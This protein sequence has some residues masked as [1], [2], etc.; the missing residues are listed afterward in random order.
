[1]RTRRGFLAAI[2][3][4]AASSSIAQENDAAPKK[5]G[6][7]QQGLKSKANKV[8]MKTLGGRQ[9]WGD[10]HYFHGWRIQRNVITKHCRL[11]DKDDVRRASG[12][13]ETCKEK[14][15]EI[16]KQQKLPAMDGKA[17]IMV[18]GIVR[19][20]KS[21]GT[22]EKRLVEDGYTVFGFDYPSTRVPI[23]EAAEYL[24]KCIKSLEGIDEIYLVVHS[25]GGLVVRSMIKEDPDPRIKRM[26]MMGVPNKGA[27]LAD[28]LKK[29]PLFKA[30]YGPAGQQLVTDNQ[31]L[32]RDLP[33]PKFEFGVIAGGRGTEKGFNPVI[34][35]DDDGTVAV[36]ST[37]LP[38][39]ADFVMEP[40]LHSFLM[41][42]KNCVEAT[43]RF[44]K[45]GRFHAD[46]PAQ[47]IT[48]E[49]AE[50]PATKR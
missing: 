12:K 25:M 2:I 47:P 31:G 16:R 44:L 49:V 28:M 48:G 18:H 1:M 13:F 50:A 5:N 14:L 8:L 30:I 15:D 35:G 43:A 29:N 9:F 26:V 41:F 11:L 6:Q 42:N 34:P 22:L 20:S 21:F 10:L 46:K 17:V 32:I 24:R 38:G 27:E 39:A 36:A 23:P 7:Q 37:R 4:L 45:S 3:A 19:S 40:V 33:T